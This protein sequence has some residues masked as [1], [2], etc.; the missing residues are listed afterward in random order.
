MDLFTTSDTPNLLPY[1]GDVIYYGKILEDTKCQFYLE[2]LLKNI[3][4]KND[5]AVIF[6]KLIVT[7][8][9]VAWYGE[10][11]F[12]YKYSNTTKTAHLWTSELLALKSLVEKVTG[13]TYNSCLLN[14]YHDGGEGMGWHSDGEKEMKKNGAIAS[15]S[16]GAERKFVFKHKQTKQTVSTILLRGSLLVMKGETQKHWLHSLPKTKKVTTPR[17]NLTFRTI[18]Q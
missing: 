2:S 9:K 1:D 11:L 18:H 7:D 14:L 12:N 6:G 10:K 3:T 16:F 13:E 4:W 5:E 8:R 15:L 17:I